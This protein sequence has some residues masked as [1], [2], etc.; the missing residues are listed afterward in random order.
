VIPALTVASLIVV[1]SMQTSF[2]DL[3]SGCW[4]K[5]FIVKKITISDK[6]G[7]IYLPSLAN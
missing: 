2:G 6:K 7:A 4:N 1:F 3:E 5:Q